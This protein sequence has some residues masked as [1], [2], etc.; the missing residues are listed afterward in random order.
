MLI[1]PIQRLTGD[2]EY[3]LELSALE[4]HIDIICNESRERLENG[5]LKSIAD[6]FLKYRIA[7]RKY[8]PTSSCDTP[9]LIEKFFICA[10]SIMSIQLRKLVIK[11]IHAFLKYLM[12]NKVL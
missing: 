6:I 9:G 4:E 7:W 1:L 11:S 12:E 2:G 10:A 8:I 5:W 3:P